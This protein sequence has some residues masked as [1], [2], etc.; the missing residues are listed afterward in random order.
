MNRNRRPKKNNPAKSNLSLTLHKAQAAMV[1]RNWTAAIKAYRQ[2]LRDDP[3][4]ADAWTDLGGAYIVTGSIDKAGEALS[5]AYQI[6]PS[7][8]PLLGNLANLKKQ[9]GEIKEAENFYR[10]ILSKDPALAR[11]WQEMAYVK[12]F[13]AG[14]TDIETMRHLYDAGQLDDEG[15]MHIAFALGKAHE[16]TGDYDTAFPYFLEGNLIKRR[17]LSM[18][19]DSHLRGMEKLIQVFDNT[20]LAPRGTIGFRDHRPI[21]IVGMPRSGTT[22]VEQ[23]LASHRS[24]YGAGELENLSHIISKTIP[25]FPV[26]AGVITPTGFSSIGQQ[27]I[28]QLGS[29][30][31][32]AQRITD[33]MPRNFLFIGLIALILP[34]ARII[35][36]RR[37]PMDTCVSCFTLH[38]P[39]GQEFSYDLGE[40][41]SYYQHYRRLMDHWHRVLPGFIFDIA[42]EDLVKNPENKTRELLGFCGLDWDKGCLDFHKSKRQIATASAVQVRE[43]PH[44]R[45]VARWRRFKQHLA[46]LKEALGSYGTERLNS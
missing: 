18:Q 15:R 39:H 2:V 32:K 3:K 41:G 36:C 16:D 1:A 31:G 34:N 33:K 35:H 20:F 21:F 12:W 22:L 46:P 38:F 42:Y 25:K 26:G 6:N 23:I 40:L 45:S 7:S 27:Y 14:D 44:T 4:N 8:I 13:R 43:P 28:R 30:A 5:H 19:I 17:T 9:I 37:S 11:A 29:L 24:V 10:E